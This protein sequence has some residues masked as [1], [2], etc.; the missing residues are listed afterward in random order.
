M[1]NPSQVGWDRNLSFICWSVYR[2]FFL[3]MFFSDIVTIN[4]LDLTIDVIF[5]LIQKADVD[6]QLIN[7]KSMAEAAARQ[8]AQVESRLQELTVEKSRAEETLQKSANE[9]QSEIISLR[10]SQ[11]AAKTE[12]QVR[13]AVCCRIVRARTL[14][15]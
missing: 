6:K 13:S 10:A 9:A 11:D 14:M 15:I 7:S 2:N 8:N 12:N 5:L 3:G 4:M 1:K